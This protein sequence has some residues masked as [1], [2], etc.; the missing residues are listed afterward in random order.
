MFSASRGRG[1]GA[2]S[3]GS[4]IRPV[5]GKP[6]QESQSAEGALGGITSSRGRGGGFSG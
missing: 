6:P 1:G 3:F 5:E 4:R 2:P